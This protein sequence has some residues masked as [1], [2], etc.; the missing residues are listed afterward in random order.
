MTLVYVKH[1]EHGGQHVPADQV[2][3]LVAAGWTRFP[4]SR[5]EK[6]AGS[7]PPPAPKPTAPEIPVFAARQ[8]EQ[9]PAKAERKP[10]KAEQAPAK[11]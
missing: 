2:E 7:W 9:A 4:R 1:P 3:R 11:A 5:A 8:P 6:A 10:A